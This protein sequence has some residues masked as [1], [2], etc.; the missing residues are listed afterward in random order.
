MALPGHPPW[1]SVVE[2]Y[3]DQESYLPGQTVAVHCSSAVATFDVTVTRIGQHRTVAWTAE[4]L[5]GALRD[6]PDTAVAD[7]CGW[8]ATFEIP[9]ADTWQPGFY[10]VRFGWEGSDATADGGTCACFVLRSCEPGDADALLVLATSTWQAYNEWGGSGL[11]RGAT[12]ISLDRPYDRGFLFKSPEFESIR[13]VDVGDDM[14]TAQMGLRRSLDQAGYGL[15]AANAGWFQWERRFVAWAEAAGYSLDYAAS[16]DLD[17]LPTILDGHRL[18]V[19]VG[20]DEYWS[21]AMRDRVESFTSSGG[22]AVF[23]SG[24][25]ASG[26]IRYHPDG[27]SWTSHVMSGD[28]TQDPAWPAG[29][30]TGL[31]CDPALGRPE[32]HMTGVSTAFAGY[33]RFGRSTPRGMRGFV[34]QRPEH[35][36]FDGTDIMWGDAIGV[37]GCLAGFELCGCDVQLVN[38]RITATGRFGTPAN[39]E[40]LAVA[41]AHLWRTAESSSL[42]DED[43]I[44]GD[45]VEAVAH[46]LHGADC[47]PADIERLSHGWACMVV[48]EPGGFVFCASTTEWAWCLDDPVIDRLTRNLMDRCADGSL[49]TVRRC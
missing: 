40:V 43:G 6:V 25:I 36:V 15:R 18:M 32:T 5:E 14:D 28:V 21:T 26:K 8:P 9:I 48:H 45:S 46:L 34:V 4:G 27:R 23:L 1:R 33:A 24:D 37:D 41:P 16:S 12:T 10:E 30:V 38:N 13:A 11:Y 47:T 42:F 44:W 49:R 7:G 39:T 2:G 29:D 22:N 17:R 31:W 19:S 35:W 3:T 20:H